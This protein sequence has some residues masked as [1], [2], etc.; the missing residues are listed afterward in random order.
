MSLPSDMKSGYSFGLIASTL[1]FAGLFHDHRVLTHPPNT[2]RIFMSSTMTEPVS[3][4]VLLFMKC[5]NYDKFLDVDLS[6]PESTWVAAQEVHG[7]AAGSSL[8]FH[9]DTMVYPEPFDEAPACAWEVQAVLDVNHTYNRNGR[10]GVDW[11]SAVTPLTG[12]PEAPTLILDRHSVP[13]SSTTALMGIPSSVTPSAAESFE[14]KSKVLSQFWGKSVSIRAWVLLPP[15]YDRHPLAHYPTAYWTHG[16]GVPPQYPAQMATKIHSRMESGRVPP[17]FW[18]MLDQRLPEGTHEFADSVN[19]GPWGTALTTEFIP[20]LERKYRMDAKPA[21]RLLTGHSSGGWATLQLQIN[22][23]EIFGGTWSTSPDPCDF[24]DFLGTNIYALNANVYRKPD[25]SPRPLVRVDGK[26]IATIE[27]IAKMEAVLGSYG[28]QFSSFEWV[29]SPRGSDGAPEPMFDRVTGAV[30]PIV[31]QYWRDHYDLAHLV[32]E[33]WTARHDLL[34]GRIHV[35]VGTA[36]TFYLDGAVQLLDKQLRELGAQAHITYI[37]G[38]THFDLFTVG[39]DELGLFD[40]I[41]KEMYAVARSS[42]SE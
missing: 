38:R 24:E 31:A 32:K 4:R 2:F 5:G 41:A 27:K 14:V 29:F 28:G 39:S 11:E 37:P 23:P 40:E 7:L 12:G 36:D 21:G 13:R 30:N 25:G 9:A 1:L 20:A 42:G 22:Y 33:H 17:M 15:G 6:H 18:V 35:I 16:F 34:K 26:V 8:E 3:G 19:T 10:E